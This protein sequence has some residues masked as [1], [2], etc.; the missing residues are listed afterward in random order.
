GRSLDGCL[1]PR[2]RRRTITLAV[3]VN[4]G[5]LA[6]FKYAGFLAANLSA[7]LTA[8]GAGP[9]PPVRVH[10]PLGISFFTF[11]ALSYVLD[12]YRGEVKSLK[13]PVDFALYIAFFPQSIAGPIVRYHDV[14]SQLSGRVVTEERFA[15][16]CRQFIYGLAKK[17]LIANTVAGVA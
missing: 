11:H 7:L 8:C 10:L 15:S 6:F 5:L 3:M 2:R 16:G 17:M 9:L 1:D 14:A 4:L 12:I 13:N